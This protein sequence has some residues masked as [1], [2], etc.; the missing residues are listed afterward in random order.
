MQ[1]W[2]PDFIPKL[3]GDV[4]E[5]EAVDRTDDELEISR[6]TPNHQLEHG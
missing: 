1:G 3:M 4:V 6:A 5:M 2:S